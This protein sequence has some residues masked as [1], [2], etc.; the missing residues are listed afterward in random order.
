VSPDASGSSTA[1]AT[2][3]ATTL[4]TMPLMEHLRELRGRLMWSVGTVMVGM[5]I[6]WFAAQPVIDALTSMCTVCDRGFIAVRVLETLVTKLRVA[7]IVGLAFAMP[8]VLYQIVAFVLPAL[9]RHEKRYLWL[10]LPG[11]S[12]LFI[13]GMAFGFT[14][15]VPRTVNFLVGFLEGTEN[16][17]VQP[18]IDDYVSFM[19]NLVLV[20]GLAFQ[21]PLVVLLLT[22]LRIV[23][24]QTLGRYRRHAVLVI[25]VA[26]AVLTPTPDPF[27]MFMV[28]GPMYILFELG[29]L[30]SRF[31]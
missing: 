21:T 18:R 20:I 29:I 4:S 22:K 23:S 11:A 16:L 26:A 10:F 8:M 31:L 2:T 28:M 15:V 7:F 3:E 27:T 25:A 6:G 13:A 12:L 9:H 24:A 1:P 17:E 30:L 19:T 14:F 5:I